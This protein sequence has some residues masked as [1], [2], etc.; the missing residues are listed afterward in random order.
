MIRA[1]VAIRGV[2]M[3]RHHN[4]NFHLSSALHDRVEV[5]HFKPKEHSVPI[6]LVGR[7]GNRPMMMLDF[8][9]VQLQDKRSIFHELLILLAA[10]STA[11]TEQA[12]VPAAAGF[13]IGNA[14]KGLRAHEVGD[15]QNDTFMHRCSS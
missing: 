14:N 12:L 6:R 11:A 10:V 15:Y 3:A 9:A 7:I 13:D 2:T 8:K 5:I 1:A 4:L